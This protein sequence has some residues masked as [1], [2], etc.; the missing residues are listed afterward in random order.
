MRAKIPKASRIVRNSLKADH[1]GKAKKFG[2]PQSPS[3]AGCENSDR[4]VPN[5]ANQIEKHRAVK[6]TRGMRRALTA[7]FRWNGRDLPWRGTTDAYAVLVSEFML[8]QTRVATVVPYFERWM[9]RFPTVGALAGAPLQEVLEHW[10]GLGYYSRARNLHAA[11]QVLVRDHGGKIPADLMALRGLPGVGA[12]TAGAVLAFAFDRPAAVL[13]ANVV[14]VL[15]RLVDFREPVDSTRGKAAMEQLALTLQPSGRGGR[16]FN[17]ALMELGALV[18][19]VGRPDCSVCPVRPH[20]HT[21]HPEKLPLKRPGRRTIRVAEDRALWVSQ[22]KIWLE[23]S[24]GP[25]WKGLW[26]LPETKETGGKPQVVIR[27]PITHHIV[28]MRVYL[29][30]GAPPRIRPGLRGHKPDGL[31]RLPMPSSHRRALRAA[32]A[33]KAAGI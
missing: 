28:T 9:R 22:G 24:R 29:H 19:R 21:R 17:S 10:Q 11:S 31:E 2:T 26:I 1:M 32:M 7:W 23:C 14:R 13:D 25:R 27:Y 15:A 20:C 12:Y 3:G 16:S 4:G 8:Q 5:C 18:C 33:G 30:R 6:D